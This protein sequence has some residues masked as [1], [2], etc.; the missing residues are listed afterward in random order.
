MLKNTTY[1][2]LFFSFIEQD[3]TEIPTEINERVYLGSS[4][5]NQLPKNVTL[6]QSA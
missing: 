6:S 2:M 5:Y 3:F 4:I 1:L